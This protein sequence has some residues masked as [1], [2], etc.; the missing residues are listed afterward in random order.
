MECDGGKG[1]CQ[2][3]LIIHLCPD[4]GYRLFREKNNAL[5]ETPLFERTPLMTETTDTSVET[6]EKIVEFKFNKDAVL[7]A[8]KRNSK[9]LIAGAA[10]F[11]AGTALTLMAFRSVP[12]TDEPEELEHDDLD[13]IDEIEASEETD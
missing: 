13:E 4:L 6:N 9:K 8:I 5:Y 12:D 7:P 3:P 2:Y 1:S 11:A 10:V